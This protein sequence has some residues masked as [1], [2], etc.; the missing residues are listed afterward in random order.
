MVLKVRALDV[1]VATLLVDFTPA[2][3]R[4]MRLE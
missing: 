4:K 2:V 3:A 1:G